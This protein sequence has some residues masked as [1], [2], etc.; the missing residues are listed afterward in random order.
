MDEITGYCDH[1]FGA[2]SLTCSGGWQ[3]VE[4][5]ERYESLRQRAECHELGALD[6]HS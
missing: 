3:L 4:M 5:F 6:L 2:D 1:V